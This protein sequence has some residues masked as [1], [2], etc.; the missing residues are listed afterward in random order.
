MNMI[1]KVKKTIDQHQMLNEGET[2]VVALSGGADSCALLSILV[3]FQNEYKMK[4][5]AAHFNHN[6]RGEISDLDETFCSNLAKKYQVPFEV[7]RL[8]S[9]LVPKGESPEEYYRRQRYRFLEKV[10][11]QH[12]AGKIALGHHLNDQAETVLLNILRGSGMEGLKGMLPVRDHRYIRPLIDV[13]KQEILEYLKEK[14][15][16]HRDDS[17]NQSSVF[18]R[19][20]IRLELLPLLKERFNP[21]IEHGLV[22]MARTVNRDHECLGKCVIEIMNSEKIQKSD[23][24]VTFSADYFSQLPEAVRYR[25]IKKLLEDMIK[26]GNGIYYSHIESVIELALNGCTGKQIILPFG[27][28]ILKQ[29][30]NILIKKN[31][32]ADKED[33]QYSLSIPGTVDLKER[34]I[35]ISARE[36]RVDEVDFGQKGLIYIDLEAVKGPLTIRNRRPGDWFVPLGT[37][38]RQKIKK[39]FIDRKLPG[40]V[41]DNIALLVDEMS[42][43]WI[44]SIHLCDRV[45]IKNGTKKVLVL[46]IRSY[47]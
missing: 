6:L 5:V 2:I 13:S 37:T 42:V 16:K 22:R 19:N 40:S 34:G 27:L 38:G 18:M 33:Y 1:Q 46:D 4:I 47:G 7:E 3:S 26:D 43:L 41:R 12:K 20:R 39:L 21:Q 8:I 29:Y 24:N 23:K 15:L 36:G 10:A 32:V 25:L 35:I 14:S 11:I 31:K 30:D 9:T 17:S 45:K 28:T 44:E